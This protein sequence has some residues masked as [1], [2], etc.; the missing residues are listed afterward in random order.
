MLKSPPPPAFHDARRSP[1]G[2][3]RPR[4][5]RHPHRQAGVLRSAGAAATTCSWSA[6]TSR[7]TTPRSRSTAAVTSCATAAPRYGTYVN[8]EAITEHP[9]KHGDLV[10]LG[11][12]GGAG[13]GVPARGSRRS[14]RSP[15]TQSHHVGRGRPPAGGGAAR[16]PPRAR[17]GPRARRS[18]GAGD[19]LGARGHRRRARL[20]HAGRRRQ[21][22]RVQDRPRPRRRVTLSGSAFE[23]SRKIPEEVFATGQEKIVADLLD[24]DLGQRAHGHRR[25]RHPPRALH[26]AEAGALPRSRRPADRREAHRACCISTA[27]RRARCCSRAA[28][29]ALETLATEAARRHRERPALSRRRSRR[30]GW[31]RKCGSRPRSSRRCCPSRSRKGAFFEAVGQSVPCRSIGGDFFDYVDLP[32]GGFGFAVGD[33]AG[34]GAPAALL[35]AVIQGVFSAQAS[36]GQLARRDARRRSTWR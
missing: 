2:H 4:S 11:R 20:H 8:G 23:T 27:A 33:V 36:S 30:R 15:P 6:A 3:R 5:A 22:A 28:R 21:H 26:A 35:T 29:A 18:A 34:K 12:S 17:I 13:A 31:S 25:A 24:G 9:L 19:G 16:R 14:R 10:R 1:R 7:A 32:D